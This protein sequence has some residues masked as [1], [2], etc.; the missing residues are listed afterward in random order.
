MDMHDFALVFSKGSEISFSPVQYNLSH[1]S[2][3]G[4]HRLFIPDEQSEPADGQ[5]YN[6][7]PVSHYCPKTRRRYCCKM[8]SGLFWICSGDVHRLHYSNCNDCILS[9]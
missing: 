4:N 3:G 8:E 9:D 1:F 2:F 7:A 5:I 6:H